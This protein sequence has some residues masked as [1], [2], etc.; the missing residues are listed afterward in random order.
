MNGRLS[1]GTGWG[2]QVMLALVAGVFSLSASGA[3]PDVPTAISQTTPAVME[4]MAVAGAAT[5]AGPH[6]PLRFKTV[7]NAPEPFRALLLR[8]LNIQRFHELPDLDGTELRRLV[9]QLP[10]DVQALLGTRGHFSPQ[11]TVALTAPDAQATAGQPEWTV[12]ATVDPGPVSHVAS[13]LLAFPGDTAP[14]LP[15]AEDLP[16]RPTPDERELRLRQRL[17]EQWPLAVGQPFSQAAW[18]NAKTEAL[19]GLTSDAFPNARL[20]GSLADVDTETHSVHLALEI[21]PGPAF[22]LGPITIEGLE[23]YETRWIENLVLAS[24]AQP[25]QPHRLQDL[26][27]AQQRLSQSGY[28]ESVFVY[29]DPDSDPTAAPIRVQ[30]R[31]TRRGRLLLG[32]GMSTGDGPRLSAEHTWNRVPGLDWRALTKVKLERSER[33]AETE[34]R[35]PVDARGWQWSAGLQAG[36]VESGST[37]TASQRIRLGKL[38]ESENLSRGYYVQYDHAQTDSPLLRLAGPLQSQRSVSVNYAWSRTRF[39]AT[40]L[41]T[42]GH[43]LA[44]EWGLGLTLG[45]KNQP[46]LRTRVR[47]LGFLPLDGLWQLALPATPAQPLQVV[48]AAAHRLGRLALRLEGGAI[49]AAASAPV[50]DSQRFWAGGDQSVRGYALREMGVRQTDGSVLPG[51]LVTVGSLEWQR[52]IVSNGVPTPWESTLFVDA[53]AVANHVSDLRAKVGVGA[54]V[55]YNSPAGPLQLDLAYGLDSKRFRIHLSVG[56]AF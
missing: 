9:N 55:R 12:H 26:Q 56:F 27:A 21:D 40:P 48:P 6:A 4:P 37:V 14:T 25:G 22:T 11:V 10:A 39:D 44:T 8:H 36:R 54:G 51:R 33:T 49:A 38:Q 45:Q 35:S 53:G 24:G 31:E 41:P 52:P 17:R 29:V 19:R 34:L 2:R 28:F 13:V 23:R 42:R 20:V 46:Y 43:G 5:P 16:A 30:V 18:D 15:A 50:P 1:T 3:E 47:W 32:M 7:V